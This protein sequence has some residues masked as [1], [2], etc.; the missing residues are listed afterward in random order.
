MNAVDHDTV[1]Y[2]Y[3]IYTARAVGR[4]KVSQAVMSDEE[5][6]A[7]L[8][9]STGLVLYLRRSTIYPS[10]TVDDSLRFLT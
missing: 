1:F 10:N 9:R 5:L 4:F 7:G 3:L 8:A 2:C 6:P